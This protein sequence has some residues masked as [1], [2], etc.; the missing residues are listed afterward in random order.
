RSTATGA[1][2]PRK[3]DGPTMPHALSAAHARPF[4]PSTG[5]LLCRGQVAP[6]NS[7]SREGTGNTADAL[8]QSQETVPR[9]KNKVSVRCSIVSGLLGHNDRAPPSAASGG[10]SPLPPARRSPDTSAMKR[11]PG[12]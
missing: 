12:L 2:F 8:E 7:L 3:V 5:A 9:E 11:R 4:I 1:E 6:E 10:A